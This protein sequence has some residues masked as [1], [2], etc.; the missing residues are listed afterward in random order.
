M[1]LALLI[2]TFL[3]VAFGETKA[4]EFALRFGPPA[5]GNGGPNPTTL[6]PLDWQISYVTD[7][8]TDFNLSLTGLLL[9]KRHDLPGK[10]Y[11]T[12]GGGFVIAAFGVGPGVYSAFGADLLCGWVCF[13]TEFVQGLSY[14]AGTV[15][16][17]YA[18]R[19][20]A[21]AWF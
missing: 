11:V 1:R 13:S 2:I 16:S 8:N 4:S 20:G 10:T 18:L 7:K 17:P 3:G 14:S 9:G 15:L 12:V 5:P 6:G 21:S 19:I